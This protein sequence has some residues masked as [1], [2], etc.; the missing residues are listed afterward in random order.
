MGDEKGEEKGSLVLVARKGCFGLP[1]ACPSCL[2]VYVYL[3]LANASFDLNFDVSN[4]DSDH[5]PY[6]EFG[7][8]V[9]FN[10]EK[11]G[12][13]DC[14]TED[15]IVDLDSKLPSLSVPEWVSTKAMISTWLA[16]AVQYELW[17]ASDGS[18]ANKI[19]FSDLPRPIGKILHWKQTRA[20]KQL[21]GITS[22]NA[23]EKEAEIYKKANMAYDALSTRLG[24]QEFLFDNRPTSVDAIF[25]GHA[26][27]VLHALPDTSVLRNSL[28]KLANLVKYAEYLKTDLLEASSSSSSSIPRSPFDA[29]TSSM[30]RK[31]ASSRWKP[32]PKAK[33]ERTEEEK[34]FRRRAKYFLATQLVAVIVFLSLFGGADGSEDGAEDGGA[35]EE[36]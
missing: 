11:G 16:Q 24:A 1:T 5:V 35:Y 26:L 7:D 8:Y 19:Y 18:I 34:I 12:V 29:S 4:P 31:S 22:L 36:D 3:R 30:P 28:L 32:K 9:A 13:I 17:V 33:R 15:S 2:P 6:V 14:L 21:C 23:A 10:N 25:L 27:F 20:V